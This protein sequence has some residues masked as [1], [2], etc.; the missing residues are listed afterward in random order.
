MRDDTHIGLQILNDF[1]VQQI[2]LTLSSWP[3]NC[4]PGC[5]CPGPWLLARAEHRVGGVMLAVCNQNL[6]F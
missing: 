4:L 2:A 5:P 3:N 1:W 6:N